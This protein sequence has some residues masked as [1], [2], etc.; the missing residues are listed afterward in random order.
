MLYYAAQTVSAYES[1]AFAAR[2]A[3]RFSARGAGWRRSSW[4][5][6]S[7]SAVASSDI[8]AMCHLISRRLMAARRRRRPPIS[9]EYRDC[10]HCQRLQDNR[11]TPMVI[12]VICQPAR[13]VDCA[14]THALLRGRL[15]HLV[16]WLPPI[17]PRRAKMMSS[18]LAMCGTVDSSQALTA[19]AMLA[20]SCDVREAKRRL[21]SHLEARYQRRGGSSASCVKMSPGVDCGGLRRRASLSSCDVIASP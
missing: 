14:A 16:A 9:R 12:I 17:R 18:M 21:V 11:S 15:M 6:R 13:N 7:I 10:R 8:H 5:R 19:A 3:R 1:E 4:R 2:E 20:P